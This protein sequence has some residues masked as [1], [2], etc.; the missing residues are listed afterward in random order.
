MIILIAESKTMLTAEKDIRPEVVE[1]T[2]PVYE[3]TAREIMDSMRNLTVGELSSQLKL[4]GSLAAKMQKMIYEFPYK[5]T[6]NRAIEAFTG[7]VFKALDFATLP[8]EAQKRG[9]AQVRII[10]SLYGWLRPQDIIK[11]YRLDFTSK[12][13][14][15]PSVGKALNAF[16]RMDVTKA[17]VRKLNEGND[18]EIINLLPADASKCIDWKLAKRFAKVWKV[19]F[20]EI[21]EGDVMKTPTAERLK[22]LRGGLLRQVLSEGIDQVSDLMHISSDKYFCEGTPQYPDHIRFLC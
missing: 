17:L 13:D 4:S 11:P 6:G 7:V 18:R 12:L 19:D 16:W 8:D 15:G 9:D 3:N 10:S 22:A 14:E 2:T 20:Q 21:K 1:A 5:L